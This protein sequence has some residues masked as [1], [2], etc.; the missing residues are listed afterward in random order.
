MRKV[1]ILSGVAAVAALAVP[2][3]IEA[4]RVRSISQSDRQQGAQAHPQLLQEFGGTYDGP[5]A[6]YV[7]QVGQRIAVQSGLSNSGSDFT[8]SLL[9]SPVNNAFAIPG[10]YVYVTRQLLGLMNDEAELAGVLGHEVGHVA[11]RHSSSRGRTSTIGAIGSLLL[12]VVTGNSQIAQIAGQAAQLYTLRFSRSQ[13]LQADDLGIRYLVGAGYDPRALASMLASLAAQTQLDAQARGGDARSLAEWASTHPDPAGRVRRAEQTAARYPATGALNREAFIRQ[14][15][16]LRYGD[17]PRQGVIDGR[18]FRHPDLRLQFSVPQGFTMSNGARAVS[19]TGQGGQAQF[20]TGSYRGDLDSYV[21][22]VLRGLSGGSGGVPQGQV[23]RTRIGNFPVAYTTTRA[24]SGSGQVDV[25]V[26]AYEFGPQTAYHFLLLTPAG[27][28]VGP[29]GPMLESLQRLS[30][31]E[32]AQIRGREIDVV[33]VGAG[34]TPQ[35]LAA[36]MAYPD[37][38]LQRFLVLNGLG[39][40]DRLVPGQQVKLVVN[41]R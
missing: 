41:S 16:G 28:G 17:D 2:A 19:V 39:Q 18:T 11:A 10:G 12:G 9:N 31:S 40:N 30:A 14:L 26:F 37:L 8:V 1:L 6:A 7:R 22:G 27:R 4:Q 25:S 20:G 3:S 5:Q 32:A 23:Q 38:Q 36:R 29:F 35:R 21:T 34:D 33:T 15:D 13:E 24:N